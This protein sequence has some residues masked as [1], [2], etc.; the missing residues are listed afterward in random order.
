MDRKSSHFMFLIKILMDLYTIKHYDYDKNI[1]VVILYKFFTAEMLER[2]VNYCFRCSHLE[3]FCRK[4][5]LRNFAKFTGN[6]LR[7][8]LFL[9]PATLLKNGA[10][11]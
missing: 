1:F 5:V 6:H 4:G 3:V 7:Q 11:R 2:H 9:R 8:T 10:K